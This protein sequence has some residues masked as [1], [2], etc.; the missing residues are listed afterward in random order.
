MCIRDRTTAGAAQT[1]F[2]GGL[3]AYSI[4]FSAAGA[5]QWATYLGGTSIDFAWAVTAHAPNLF[6]I[7]GNTSSTSGVA[8]PGAH[9]VSLTGPDESLIAKYNY[10]PV[11]LPIE[12]LVFDAETA[13][14]QQVLTSWTTATESNNAYFTVERSAD[15]AVFTPVGTVQGAGNSQ[16]LIRYTWLDTEPLSGLS[17]Y[18][19]RQ[20]DF[21]GTSTTSALAAVHRGHGAVVILGNP[22]HEQLSLVLPEEMDV[23][24]IDA[25]SRSMFNARLSRGTQHIP[26]H[27]W[28]SGVYHV[29]TTTGSA[30]SAAKVVLVR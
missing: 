26:V 23:R 24:V 19:L 13:G 12:L 14:A 10:M 29:I 21:D 1:V 2:G 18:R 11:V 8:T 9:D 25:G 22:I 20:T 17:Y 28:D 4:L 7:A 16:Q 30:V 15:A 27:T 3:D 5:R 6:Y